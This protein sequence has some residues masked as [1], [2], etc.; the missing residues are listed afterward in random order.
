LRSWVALVVAAAVVVGAF[1]S[2]CATGGHRSLDLGTASGAD[3]G[4]E[5]GGTVAT[6]APL[7]VNTKLISDTALCVPGS[8]TVAWSPLR[9]ISRDE[10]DNMV[11][12]LLGDTTQPATNFVP[13]S[14]MANGVYFETN[15]YTSVSTLVAQQYQQAAETLAQ[16]A[17]SSATTLAAILPCQ[18]QDDACAQQFIASF[19]NKAFRGQFDSTESSQLFQVYSDVK[20]QF[21]FPTGIQ[22]IITAVLESP[23]FLYVF[24]F[25]QGTATGNVVALSPYEVAARLSLFLWRSV[26][27]D[28]LMQAAAAG[29]LATPTQVEAQAV[30]M[31]ADA[32]AVNAIQDFTMQFLQLQGTPTLGKD[33]QF[34]VW[35]SDPQIGAEMQD[36]TLTNV[37]QLVLVENGGLAELLTSPSSY[38]NPHLATF[39]GT[40]QGSAPGV[41]VNDSALV[42]GQTTF[43]KTDLSSSSR[44][45]ILTNG[46]VM[47]T[48][49]HTSLPSSVLR[50]KLVREELLCDQLQQPP[51]GIP[52][53]ATSVPEGGTT[54][55]LS[56]A[57]ANMSTYCY[58]CHQY[59]D[60]IGF[61]F[62]HFDATGAY[63]ATDANGV[64]MGGPFPPIDATGQV[65]ARSAGEF[66]TTFNGATDLVTQLAGAAQVQQ[67]FVV[68]ELRYALSR[69]ETTDDAC[70]AQ[71]V[72]A[73][74]SS[75]QFNIQKLLVAL[76]GSDAFRYR[77]VET[78][79]SA[80]Q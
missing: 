12:D 26:P 30:R 25:G 7:P 31:L 50:G 74:F 46:A 63:Q 4:G 65:L 14:P 47:A 60:P 41:T 49:A 35:T 75:S 32:K 15:T 42:Q 51:P 56:A 70:S 13:E 38:V 52:P 45:G 44:A 80:C 28:T 2:G 11:R 16:T 34:N 19:A 66:A 24:E 76:T 23:R 71:Q 57:H 68:Q 54:R 37:S 22:A 17:V 9:R 5:D 55:A 72:F 27:D 29:Q 73:A 67:C 10:Y 36:E 8:P 6:L 53:P 64:T 79:G 48:Q 59:M 3:A 40:P 21:D 62:G 77:S 58:S 43:V 78:S 33:T 20:A 18:T 1:A 39:Y 61:G 69:I